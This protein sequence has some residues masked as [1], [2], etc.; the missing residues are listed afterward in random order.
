MQTTYIYGI[1]WF[2]IDKYIYVGKANDIGIRFKDHLRCSHNECVRKLVEEKGVDN[3]GIEGLEEVRFKTSEEWIERERFW[4]VKFR[5][6]GHPLCNRN[7]GGCG[8]TEVSDEA[9]IRIGERSK[10]SW[11]PERRKD[12]SIRFSGTGNPFYG[13]HHT[14]ETKTELSEKLSGKNSP[15]YGKKFPEQGKL[16][17]GKGNPRYGK[18][19]YWAG[20]KNPEHSRRMAGEG[21]PFY[22]KRHPDEILDKLDLFRPGYIPWNR[23]LPRSAECKEKIGKANAKLFPAFYNIKT[24]EFIPSGKNLKKVCEERDLDYDHMAYIKGAYSGKDSGKSSR[25]GWRLATESEIVCFS[26]IR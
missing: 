25:R 24:G 18:P 6:E 20:K 13:K 1:R 9:R 14:S 4:V 2:E 17:S 10:A 21:N 7:D 15:R 16:M 19:G 3:F 5:E 11:T 8:P 23:G 22:G 12:Q 26:L